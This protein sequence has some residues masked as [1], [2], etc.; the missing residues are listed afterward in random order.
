MIDYL[1]LILKPTNACNMRCRHCYHEEKGYDSSIM[2][3][4]LIE[5]LF[6][7]IKNR[8]EHLTIIWHG[9]EPLM[10]GLDYFKQAIIIENDILK[11]HDVKNSIQTNASLLTEN[12]IDFFNN[13]H[14]NIGVSFD[15]QFNDLLRDKTAIVEKNIE[16][17]K[18][19]EAN[20][21]ALTVITAQTLDK[22]IDIYNYFKLHNINYKFA[23]IF[24][25]G[26]AKYNKHLLINEVEYVKNVRCFFDYWVSDESCNIHVDNFEKFVNMCLFK[27][28]GECEYSSCLFHFLGVDSKGQ[29]YPCGRSYSNEYNLGNVNDYAAIDEI[30]ESLAYKNILLSSINRREKCKQMCDEFIYCQG[31]C[32]NNAIM[33]NGI[34]N[35]NGFS[36][37]TFRQIFSYIKQRVEQIQKNQLVA[38]NPYLNNL[39][40]N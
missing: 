38:L 37:K 27:G 36:C 1:T 19:K 23:Y 2:P 17:L 7:L 3:F 9:G 26:S 29:L 25:S 22:L 11:E 6:N 21:G 8:V 15:G 10:V 30:F 28:V 33:E 31:G 16:L 40:H 5:K 34:Q 32:N 24:E 14:F 12:F 4:S 13:Y 35:N 18:S 39:L 20:F